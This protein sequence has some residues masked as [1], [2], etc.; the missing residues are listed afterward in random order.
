ME[1]ILRQDYPLLGYEGDICKVKNGYARNY[2]FP[3]SI[4]MPATDANLRSLKALQ[5]NI[6]KKKATRTIDASGT[7]EKLEATTIN[8]P[9]K[10]GENEKMYGSVSSQTVA[11]ALVKAG[12]PVQKRDVELS[13]HIKS[14]G[15]FT[16]RVKVY[17][18]VYADVKIW[19]AKE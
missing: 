8:I 17:T 10:V 13:D 1:V 11:D 18:G 4:A 5:K 14:L 15:A 12:F 16:V 19:V 9:V 3:R 2:L 6:E 7:K